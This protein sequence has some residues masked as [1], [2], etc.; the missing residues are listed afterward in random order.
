MSLSYSTLYTTFTNFS[1]NYL[2]MGKV[3]TDI[4]GIK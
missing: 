4:G 3:Y 2:V 1:M